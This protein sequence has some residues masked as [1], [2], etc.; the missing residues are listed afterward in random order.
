MTSYRDECFAKY[1]DLYL[2]FYHDEKNR[3][4]CFY[5]GEAARCFDHQ[6]PI[7]RVSDYRS[8]N[9]RHEVYIKVP[10]CNNC[11]ELA[12]DCLTP[13]LWERH[14]L[15]KDKLRTKNKKLLNGDIWTG[16]EMKHLGRNLKSY[17]AKKNRELQILEERL[18][19]VTG[20]QAYADS[21]DS[22]IILLLFREI[23]EL[24]IQKIR[25]IDNIAIEMK[26]Y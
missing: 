6:P 22:L 8:L 21:N 2:R 16:V 14:D 5:C 7:T 17:I 11:N 3:F 10:S 12:S 19:Y 23:S 9:L 24:L 15:I 25:E 1:N 26:E 20:I 18:N 4:T 13:T